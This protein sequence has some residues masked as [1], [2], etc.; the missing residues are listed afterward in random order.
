MEEPAGLIDVS[1]TILDFLHCPAPP[2]F[3]GA[4]LL[5]KPERPIYAESVHAHDSFGWSPLRSIRENEFKY[6][7][8]P[9]P[10]LYDLR[11][12]PGEHVN[13]VDKNPV[14]ARRL[15][16]D[17]EK[18]LASHSPK[19]PAKPNDIAPQTRALL[20]SLGYL[21]PGPGA[22]LS[23]TGAD[24]KDRLPEFQ[25]YE[26]AMVYLYERRLDAA[27]AALRQ[28]LARDPHNTLA[29]RDLGD[30]YLE[31]HAYSQARAN[32]ERVLAAAADDYVAQY[33]LG[34]ADEHLGLWKEA[35]DHLEAA[36]RLAPEAAQCRR[37]LEKVEG[38]LPDKN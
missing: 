30:C 26:Q 25:L 21:A 22:K 5:G 36:C 1:P 17:L 15:R 19:N 3:E 18:L 13:I 38:K 6:I 8:A 28:L 33:E 16:G 23:V 37:E 2:S 24:P 20:G 10:E 27:I 4:S 29:R 9:K 12:D 11:D 35:R 7:E 31:Q 32:L 14:E 34:I